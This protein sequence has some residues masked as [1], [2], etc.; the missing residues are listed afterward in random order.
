MCKCR[1]E[2]IYNKKAR[3]LGRALYNYVNM[4]S[5]GQLLPHQDTF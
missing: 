5:G 1:V 4:I 3:L 2:C